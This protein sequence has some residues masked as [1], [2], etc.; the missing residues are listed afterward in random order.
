M[1]KLGYIELLNKMKEYWSELRQLLKDKKL[2]YNDIEGLKNT[3][4]INRFDDAIKTA[5][6]F[7]VCSLSDINLML[8]SCKEIQEDKNRFIPLKMGDE[9]WEINK[10]KLS[11]NRY[12]PPKKGFMYLGIDMKNNPQ[13]INY[14][15]RN[16]LKEIRA[17]EDTSNEYVSTLRFKTTYNSKNKKVLDF[18]KISNYNTTDDIIR[19]F[20]KYIEENKNVNGD[21][22]EVVESTLIK[23]IL[24]LINDSTF[25]KVNKKICNKE[26]LKEKLRV[27]YAP[28]HAFANYIE[29][30][31]YAGIIYNSTV[32]D[33]LNLVLF[34]RDDV[35][36]CDEIMIDNIK[37]LEYQYCGEKIYPAVKKIYDDGTVILEDGSTL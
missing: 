16:C 26:E 33:G 27:E 24:K 14:I 21:F 19:E 8:R 12:N 32:C 31:G 13:N 11:D 5:G 17:F 18:S 10:E 22:K 25:R 2:S 15:K 36:F 37:D 4:F 28:F 9:K 29:S 34:N 7:A 35:E 23:M 6:K 3:H 1:N 20:E 30:I